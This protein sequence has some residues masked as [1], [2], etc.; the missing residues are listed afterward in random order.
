[1]SQLANFY[2]IILKFS[3]FSHLNNH[4]NWKKKGPNLFEAVKYFLQLLLWRY[5]CGV[6]NST[7]HTSL[8]SLIAF[9]TDKKTKY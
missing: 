3:L 7:L 2:I 9:Q 8:Y 6:A 5:F 1:M 4:P